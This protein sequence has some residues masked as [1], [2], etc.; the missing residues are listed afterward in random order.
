[1]GRARSRARAPGRCEAW[2]GSLCGAISPA[3]TRTRTPSQVVGDMGKVA[4][5][6]WKMGGN[7]L[8]DVFKGLAGGIG[9]AYADM[10]KAIMSAVPGTLL[11]D[12]AGVL[13]NAGINMAS[14]AN[15]L[16]VSGCSSCG[17]VWLT[18]VSW[19]GAVHSR[20]PALLGF[21]PPLKFPAP[22]C[23]V[24]DVPRLLG[25][26]TDIVKPPPQSSSLVNGTSHI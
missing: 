20:P 2:A 7:T 21:I 23:Y 1:M 9:G 24:G 25:D 19:G 11:S 12:V 6:L 3:H 13:N 26:W 5:S 4:G 10:A 14:V 18:T 8:S 17:W 22:G 16:N 15:V